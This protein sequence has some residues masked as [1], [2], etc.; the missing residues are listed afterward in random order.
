MV[1][2]PPGDVRLLPFLISVGAVGMAVVGVFFGVGVLSLAPRYPAVPSADRD[3]Q[4]QAVEAHEVLPPAD[5]TTPGSSAPTPL[6]NKTAASPDFRMLSRQEPLMLREETAIETKLG[7]APRIVHA[8]K[9]G[10]GRHHQRTA[11][12]WQTT[13]SYWPWRPDAS[14]GP[15][16]GGGFYR[17]RNF[18]L[19]HVNP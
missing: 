3:P 14:A 12:F 13:A 19:G 10:A 16:P 4:V 7:A 8:K 2:V 15:E 9:A 18:D 5:D 17:A 6:D 11:N 1:A